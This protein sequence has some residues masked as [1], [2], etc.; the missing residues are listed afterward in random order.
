MAGELK[1]EALVPWTGPNLS[2]SISADHLLQKMAEI[3][4]FLEQDRTVGG[5]S[6]MPTL[7]GA[8]WHP[9]AQ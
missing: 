8:V 4:H 7:N 3:R 9:T 5:E 6:C 2:K 1:L